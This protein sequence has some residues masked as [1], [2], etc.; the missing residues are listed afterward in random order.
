MIQPI[1]LWVLHDVIYLNSRTNL[2]IFVLFTV[3]RCWYVFILR[4][5]N[6]NP[7]AS[8]FQKLLASVLLQTGRSKVLLCLKIIQTRCIAS[9]LYF[10]EDFISSQDLLHPFSGRKQRCQPRVQLVD[11]TNYRCCWLVVVKTDSWRLTVVLLSPTIANHRQPQQ[12]QI[13]ILIV[14]E[15]IQHKT[16][17]DYHQWGVKG[18]RRPVVEPCSCVLPLRYLQIQRTLYN[19]DFFCNYNL[20]CICFSIWK[21]PSELN[22]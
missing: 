11:L 18:T 10:G 19:Q 22:M 12:V 17:R 8:P 21:S 15:R 20:W 13:Q 9:W 16:N 14:S 3:H 6:K 2:C 1:S 5:K 4:K 7:N